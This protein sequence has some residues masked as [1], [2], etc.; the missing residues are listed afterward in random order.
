MLTDATCFQYGES[1]YGKVTILLEV[2][3]VSWP[4][5]CSRVDLL[6]VGGLHLEELDQVVPHGNG[7]DTENVAQAIV[8]TSLHIHC[9]N[10]R[11]KETPLE[12]GDFLMRKEELDGVRDSLT[13]ELR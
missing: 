4:G 2:Q 11:G 8:P 12:E 10:T 7:H 3:V 1:R 5:V 6:P 9:I 13:W